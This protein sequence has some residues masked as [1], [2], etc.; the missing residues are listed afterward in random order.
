LN[1]I[2][3][4]RGA[5]FWAGGLDSHSTTTRALAN[6]ST[7]VVC[8]ID[9]KKTPEHRFPTQRDEVIAVLKWLQGEHQR[10]GIKSN[11]FVLFGESA[12]AT[13][14][15]SVALK[16]R[17]DKSPLIAG[18]S[19]F[20]TN[21]AGPK[22]TLRAYSQWVWEQYLGH[23][24][25][26]KDSNAVP[27]LDPLNDMPPVWIG[28]GEDDPLKEDSI[29]LCEKLSNNS[30]LVS[31]KVYPQLP[32]AFLMYSGTL[33]PAFEALKEASMQC[34]NFFSQRQP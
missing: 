6:L 18:L 5:G 27:L 32:H 8:A 33:L 16:L 26:S 23:P 1:C 20:Y 22:P 17:D 21:A 12:G 34:Q 28:V 25:L 11:Q 15:L 4:I 9:Y 2:V 3:F 29:Q 19:L 24:G 30:S 7:C 31:M 14:A 10:L 13:I